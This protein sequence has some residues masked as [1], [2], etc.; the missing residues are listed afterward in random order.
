MT[1]SRTGG[2]RRGLKPPGAPLDGVLGVEHDRDRTRDGIDPGDVAI[3]ADMSGIDTED[4]LVGVVGRLEPAHVTGI[5][6]RKSRI[7]DRS[8]DVARREQPRVVGRHVGQ[9]RSIPRAVVRHRVHA[10]PEGLHAEAR[11]V[12]VQVGDGGDDRSAVDLIAPVVRTALND[13]ARWKRTGRQ[14]LVDA[15]D[16]GRQIVTGLCEVVRTSLLGEGRTA[17]RLAGHLVAGGVHVLRQL[18][19]V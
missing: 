15:A 1:K 11:Q 10:D 3:R 9:L 4:G 18:R 5:L 16:D 17:I 7:D 6:E 14:V 8:V 12:D 13:H 2:S 19:A